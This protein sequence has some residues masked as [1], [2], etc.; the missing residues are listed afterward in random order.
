MLDTSVLELG[1]LSAIVLTAIY[2]Y[3]RASFSYWK[4]RGVPSLTPTSPFGNLGSAMFRGKNSRQAINELY[5]EFEG[6]KFAGVYNFTTPA[7]L[8]RD[9]DIIK[10]AIVKDFDKFHS[11]GAVIDEEKEPLEA[12]LAFLSG[13]K[14]RN[15]RVKLTPTFTS[16]KMKMMFGTLADCGRELQLCLEPLASKGQTIEVKDVLARYSTDIIASCAFGIQCNSLKNPDAEF[17]NWGRKIFEPTFKTRFVRT[18]DLAL[19]SCPRFFRIRTSPKDVDSYFMNMVSDTV[20][21]REKNGVKR[22]D[23][24]D[25]MIQLKNKTLGVAE[26]EDTSLQN[27]DIDDLKTNTPFGKSNQYTHFQNITT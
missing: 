7:L 21:Y 14:W 20:E 27:L 26:A 23:F 2:L 4:K 8:L 5:K 22:N 13:S 1:V 10:N 25:L 12:N 3:F 16:G 11:R 24:M 17:R 19:S 15:L 9:P 6:H 18:I